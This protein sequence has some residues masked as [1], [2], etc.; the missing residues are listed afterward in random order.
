[1]MI[2]GLF[3]FFLLDYVAVNRI[4]MAYADITAKNGVVHV[5]NQT[6]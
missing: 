6:L 4:T 2:D 5:L 3:A 1:M